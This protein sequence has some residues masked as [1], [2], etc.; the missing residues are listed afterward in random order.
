LGQELAIVWT[1]ATPNTHN[2]PLDE[3]LLHLPEF[4][5]VRTCLVHLPQGDVHEVVT[6]HEVAVECHAVL[7]LDQLQVSAQLV[8]FPH[9]P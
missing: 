5:A 7:Q 9:P 3:H 1:S 4:L 2:V 8:T 6:F